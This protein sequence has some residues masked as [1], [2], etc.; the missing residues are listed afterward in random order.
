MVLSQKNY[1]F[2]IPNF[3]YMKRLF[4]ACVA[5]FFQAPLFSQLIINE[6]SQGESGAKEYVE[7]LVTGNP[8]CGGSNT[9]DLR[10]WII[11]DNN[12]WHATGS[13]TGIAGGHVK[14]DSIPQWA[15]VKIG[16]LILIYNDADMSSAVSALPV[17]TIDANGDCVYIIPISSGVLLKNITLPV[18]NGSM[19]TYA[20]PGNVY[21]P[22]GNWICLGMANS[23]DAFHVV[24]PAN[25]AV[26]HHAIGWGNNS[27]QVNV[28]YS[29]SQGGNVIYMANTNSNDPF[30]AAN[31]IDTT[32]TTS[33]TPGAPNNAAN[34][35]WILSLNN[36]CQP[37]TLPSVSFNNPGGLGCGNST[38]TIV[39]AS[40]T[41]GAL[42][43]WSNNVQGDSNIVSSPGMYYV[44]VSDA[45][46]VCSK[47][48]SINVSS[49]GLL[50]LSASSTN[51]TC[52]SNNG[53][54]SVVATSG[55]ASGY[56]WSNGSTTATI[57][58][59]NSGTYSVTVTE[60][61]GCTATASV[62]VNSTGSLSINA[63][64]V[65]TTCGNSNG[66]VTVAV[67]S[68][69]AI[70]YLW[71]NGATTISV[72]NLPAGTYSVTVDAGG[73]CTAT[74]S[75]IVNGS[76]S[77]QVSIQSA[78]SVFC[79]G[80]STQVCA[81]AGFVSYLW[82]TGATTSCI[83]AK[84]AGNYRVTVT[85]NANCTASSN[86]I[87]L[88]VYPLPPVSVSVNGDT[89]KAFNA[90]TYQWYLNGA[91]ISGATSSVYVA[92]QAGSYQV[93]V[94]DS[95]G[96]R[97][98]SN[99]VTLVVSINDAAEWSK[100]VVYPNPIADGNW[101]IQASST[102]IGGSIEIFDNN[103]RV[104]YSARINK[105]VIAV[106]QTF[107]SG[108]YFIKIQSESTSYVKKIVKL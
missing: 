15:N 16:T 99:A 81:P 80:D 52:G 55:T 3:H 51:A 66:S 88:A 64:A 60:V 47:L 103:G 79:S 71:S 9:V 68:G 1:F 92:Q 8:V 23:S 74:A 22:S 48:D 93:A 56:L 90:V 82:N 95:V 67:T 76:G 65:G 75:A 72:S 94:T 30:D 73:G 18:S 34:A 27:N 25:Y 97:A 37:F 28:Y 104:V 29:A 100:V 70:G 107:L 106:D 59:L 39:A 4:I 20:V 61:G 17:D 7:L 102:F 57:S 78:D 19:T 83:Q 36:N 50:S 10:G 26:P 43:S 86:T 41:A 13:G 77:N 53:S 49:S 85:D 62:V 58:N 40:G 11:D 2:R 108:V 91:E 96:C 69:T 84:N 105:D 12:S 24:S 35:A 46:G 6:L 42:F 32:A 63:T 89:L 31:Y 21:S 101:M 44:T 54:A 98:F 33:E 45:A 5:I 38:V 14:F 87:P